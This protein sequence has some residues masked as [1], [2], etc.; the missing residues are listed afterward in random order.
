MNIDPELCNAIRQV[1]ASCGN[2]ALLPSPLLTFVRPY[3]TV[4]HTLADVQRHLLHLESRGD[5]RRHAN[6][7]NPE[8]LSWSLTEAG[9]MLVK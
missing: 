4:P 1:L 5:V 2:R 6:P 8:I 3:I 7:D 9:H